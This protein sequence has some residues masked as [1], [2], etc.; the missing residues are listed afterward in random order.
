MAVLLI[1][2]NFS[3]GAI[4]HFDTDTDGLDRGDSTEAWDGIGNPHGSAQGRLA[5]QRTDMG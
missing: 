2:G 5:S 4:R 3:F 1:P